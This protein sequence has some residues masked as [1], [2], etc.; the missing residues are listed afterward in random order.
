MQKTRKRGL[1]DD[2]QVEF[3][4]NVVY[5]IIN[6]IYLDLCTNIT[7]PQQSAKHRNFICACNSE[8]VTITIFVWGFPCG[9]SLQHFDKIQ[10]YIASLPNQFLTSHFY[11]YKCCPLLGKSDCKGFLD[12]TF[13]MTRKVAEEHLTKLNKVWPKR[14][15]FT[16][17][18]DIRAILTL[19]GET[20]DPRSKGN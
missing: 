3:D 4:N 7:F 18:D 10:R 5:S 20:L 9:L 11:E 8:T 19:F 2:A 17:D 14:A 13:T 12:I 16:Y 15:R 6:D 1:E